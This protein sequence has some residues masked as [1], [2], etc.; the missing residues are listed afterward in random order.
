[1]HGPL[2]ERGKNRESRVT[3]YEGFLSDTERPTTPGS[4]SSKEARESRGK[5]RES[6][7]TEYERFLSGTERPTTPGSE[8]SKEARE[9]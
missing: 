6:R 2:P 4:E 7:V 1:M 3:E 5:D 8:S 9:S